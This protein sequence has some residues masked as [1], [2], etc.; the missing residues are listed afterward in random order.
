MA[1]VLCDPLISRI[2]CAVLSKLHSS[3]NDERGIETGLIVCQT[4]YLSRK[5]K[6]SLRKH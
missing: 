4:R 3:V 2:L 5:E 1:A 6:R